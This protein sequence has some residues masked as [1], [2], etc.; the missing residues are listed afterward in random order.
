[1]AWT[2]FLLL[3]YLASQNQPQ[4]KTVWNPW[5]ILGVEEVR[6]QPCFVALRGRDLCG[7]GR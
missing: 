1:V 4:Q 6:P 7:G 5:E 2:L 3:A